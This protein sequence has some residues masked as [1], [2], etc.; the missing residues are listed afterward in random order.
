MTRATWVALWAMTLINVTAA[1]VSVSVT[2][3]ARNDFRAAAEP[4]G[5]FA[6]EILDAID[7]LERQPRAD[8]MP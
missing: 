6:R 1:A 8:Q 4:I 5:R 3:S 2:A 7:D